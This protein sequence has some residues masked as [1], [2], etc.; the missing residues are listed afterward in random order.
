M[1]DS[2]VTDR[3]QGIHSAE[4][5]V[6]LLFGHQEQ[7]RNDR[8]DTSME[9][10]GGGISFRRSIQTYNP[11]SLLNVHFDGAHDGKRHCHTSDQF[12]DNACHFD[13]NDKLIANYSVFIDETLTEEAYI[14]G[15]F[16]V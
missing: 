12:G 1:L 5:R 3:R 7:Q 6:P 9:S 16:E 15:V 11:V 8:F 4:W 2:S 14:Y 10:T 13:W